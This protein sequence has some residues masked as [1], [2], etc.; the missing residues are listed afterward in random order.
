MVV[1]LHIDNVKLDRNTRKE[2][3]AIGS[4]EVILRAE[5]QPIC[6][7]DQRRIECEVRN[8]AVSVRRFTIDLLPSLTFE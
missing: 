4:R 2:R 8:S 3:G 7:D 6:A 1:L 5:N